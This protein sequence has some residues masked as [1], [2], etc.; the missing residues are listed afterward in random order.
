MGA[1]PDVK[2]TSKVLSDEQRLQK[3]QMF[4]S[5]VKD[6]LAVVGAQGANTRFMLKQ[7]GKLSGLTKDEID[8]VLPQNYDELKAE[9]E[10]DALNNGKLVEVE[11]TDDDMIH[12]EI[13]NKAKDGPQ[14]YAHMNAHKRNMLLKKERPELFPQKDTQTEQTDLAAAMGGVEGIG[15]MMKPKP[16]M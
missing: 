5:Y 2:I 12:M 4:R 14:K 1:D 10:N 8:R 16:T 11:P 3:L 7:L 13:H 15:G 6:V 9:D